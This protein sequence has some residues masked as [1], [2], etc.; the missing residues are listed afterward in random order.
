M[1]LSKYKWLLFD[2]DNTLM[3]FHEPSVNSFYDLCREIGILATPEQ[4]KVYKIENNKVWS[5][6]EEGKITSLELRSLRFEY[7]F[8][9]IQSDF[10]PQLA[11]EHYI[12]G[13]IKYSKPT[14]ATMQILER[15]TKTHSLAIITNGLREA[16]RARLK[17]TGLDAFFK[18]IIVS[19]EIGLAKPQVG[20]FDHVIETE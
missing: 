18:E 3:D 13:L 7:F 1:N 6:Y 8:D 10:S 17:N 4:Y 11:H 20:Y 19:D 15:L 14:Q 16:Q 12:T 2:L 5:M 9:R